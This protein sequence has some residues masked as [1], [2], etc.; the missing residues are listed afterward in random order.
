MTLC[1]SCKSE[2]VLDPHAPLG[3]RD[4]C[5]DC[6][7]DLHCCLNCVLHDPGAHNQCRETTADFVRD[8]AK[9]NF[10]GHFKFKDG[11]SDVDDGVADARAKLD[12]LFGNLK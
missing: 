6:Y 11:E 12:A 4:D 10:C 9:F 3:V 8:R 2:I 5:P 1:H 7:A